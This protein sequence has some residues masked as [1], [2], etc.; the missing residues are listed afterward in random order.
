MHGLSTTGSN[1]MGKAGTICS[2]CWQ[3]HSDNALA[4]RAYETEV[5]A[6]T[7]GLGRYHM[8]RRVTVKYAAMLDAKYLTMLDCKCIPTRG[9]G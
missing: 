3:P 2:T 9:T 6:A 5:K 7:T 8:L 4:A 1:N